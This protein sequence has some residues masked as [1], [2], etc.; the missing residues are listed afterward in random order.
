MTPTS[1]SALWRG[2]VWCVF[3][4]F[5]FEGL[6]V[7]ALGIRY[8]LGGFSCEVTFLMWWENWTGVG[9]FYWEHC[10]ENCYINLI[11]TFQ[12]LKSY[13]PRNL[14]CLLKNSGVNHSKAF[15]ISAFFWPIRCHPARPWCPY[16][17]PSPWRWRPWQPPFGH[18]WPPLRRRPVRRVLRPSPSGHEGAALRWLQG[19]DFPTTKSLGKMFNNKLW[20]TA[21]FFF[22]RVGSE[23]NEAG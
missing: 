11:V 9:T 16:V 13:F 22:G 14:T 19:E 10:P 5:G 8:Q 12:I 1:I 21:A 20:N 23:G 6:F 2:M 3:G 15:F 17:Y 7:C 4:A 18:A